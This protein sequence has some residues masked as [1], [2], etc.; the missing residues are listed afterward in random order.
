M[1]NRS[2]L[3][4]LGLAVAVLATLFSLSFIATPVKFLAADV[5]MSHLLAVGRETFRASV[6][7]ESILL[8]ALF[9]SARG[10]SRRLIIVAIATVA[11]Q[12][13]VIMPELDDRTMAQIAGSDSVWHS[14]R[15]ADDQPDA[16]LKPLAAPA[17][18]TAKAKRRS[19][20]GRA[21]SGS[22][23]A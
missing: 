22:G 23:A 3:R 16:A 6:A 2:A 21:A 8:F 17:K 1:T 13:I 19:A 5:P 14:D 7:I 12:W 9:V 15:P 4:T 10:T 20:A 18:A 11:L